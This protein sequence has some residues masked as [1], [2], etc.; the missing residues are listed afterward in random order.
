MSEALQ[1]VNHSMP[2][3]R[4]FVEARFNGNGVATFYTN[5]QAVMPRILFTEH[6]ERLKVRLLLN[7]LM[8]H[9]S[10]ETRS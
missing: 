3:S 1:P 2:R 5:A 4:F 10:I 6:T 8:T 9:R 7:Q